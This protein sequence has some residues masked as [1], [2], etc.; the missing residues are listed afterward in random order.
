MFVTDE[1]TKTS[2]CSISAFR[3]CIIFFLALCDVKILWFE[4]FGSFY[5]QTLN[6]SK[7]TSKCNSISIVNQKSMAAKSGRSIVWSIYSLKSTC[8]F[9]KKHTNVKAFDTS[10]YNAS[11]IKIHF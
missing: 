7:I 2:Y 11:P 1:K 5:I 4:S 3:S 9:E 6:Q 10:Y 8:H